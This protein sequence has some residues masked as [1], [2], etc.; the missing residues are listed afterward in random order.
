METAKEDMSRALVRPLDTFESSQKFDVL[1]SALLRHRAYRLL[2][3][4]SKET[5]H[6]LRSTNRV[7]KAIEYGDCQFRH[8]RKRANLEEDPMMFQ[9]ASTTSAVTALELSH[10]WRQRTLMGVVCY[11]VFA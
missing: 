9:T 10:A 6:L 4:S 3:C 8:H 7:E 5:V 2:V 11:G 1:L